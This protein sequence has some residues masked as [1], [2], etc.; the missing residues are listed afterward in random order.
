MIV[1][2]DDDLASRLRYMRK[3]EPEHLKS[4]VISHNVPW[5]CKLSNLNAAL[6]LVQLKRIDEI[7][8]KRRKVVGY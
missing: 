7:L 2:D 8:E 1:T 5:Q 6:G 4:V 3:R